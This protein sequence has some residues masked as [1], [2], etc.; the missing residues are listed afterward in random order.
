MSRL[1]I[2]GLGEST[3]KKGNY[4]L[5][6]NCPY[7]DDTKSHLGVHIGRGIFHCFKC[8]SSGRIEDIE[9]K[10]DDFENRVKRF[11]GEPDSKENEAT[12]WLL[13]LP[14]FSRRILVESGLPYR[15]LRNRMV[16][17][18]EIQ[19]Y[20][21]Y[22]CNQGI[23]QDRIIVPIYDNQKLVYFVGRAYTNRVPKYLN[24]PVPKDEIIFKTF[25]GKVQTAVI[26]EGIF[27]SI[28]VGKYFHSISL[29]GK[30]ATE[31]QIQ[32]VVESTD[33]ALIMLDND[34]YTE[35]FK[36][37]QQL[38]VYINCK[39]LLIKEKDPGSMNKLQIMEAINGR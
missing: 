24:A 38:S 8:N 33:N 29:L 34:A 18:E 14:P 10:I 28:R 4:Q 2:A 11:L 30:V 1:S 6:F 19:Y 31:R 36:L 3:R 5:Y 20:N 39:I 27:D 7:C 17:K 12:P 22:Y 13:S 23:F 16:T 25:G 26:N 32:S 9:S 21:M 15:Y 37:Y 35:A